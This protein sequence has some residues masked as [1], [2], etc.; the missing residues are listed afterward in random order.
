MPR[1]PA[2][3]LCLALA[4]TFGAPAHAAPGPETLLAAIRKNY[5]ASPSVN[6]TFVQQYAPAGFGDTAPETG[7]LILQAPASLRF[8]YDGSEGKL[9]T[10]DG[11]SARQY[12]A[13]DRQMVVKALTPVRCV[14]T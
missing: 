4:A 2:A 13:A 1:L 10:F 9:F 14:Q 11:K 8:E 5:A 3:G 6:V 12:V 7:R